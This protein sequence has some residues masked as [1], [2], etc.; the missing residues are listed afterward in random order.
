MGEK[1]ETFPE[2]HRSGAL[3]V[4]DMQGENGTPTGT[5]QERIAEMDIHFRHEEGCEQFG[6]IAGTVGELDHH[7]LAGAVRNV[8]L[9][10]KLLGAVGVAHDDATDCRLVGLGN[11]EG[12]NDDVVVS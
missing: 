8:V 3:D 2:K 6:K 12:E 4:I 1:L 11:A 9:A 5:D 10:E 7:K